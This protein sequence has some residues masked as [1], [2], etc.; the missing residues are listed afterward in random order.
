[1]NGQIAS[2]QE[3]TKGLLTAQNPENH[4]FKAVTGSYGSIYYEPVYGYGNWFRCLKE[5]ENSKDAV[6]Q[7][8]VEDLIAVPKMKEE[9]RARAL[10]QLSKQGERVC[11]QDF[12]EIEQDPQSLSELNYLANLQ[13]ERLATFV[14]V[15]NINTTIDSKA[16]I[17]TC[18]SDLVFVEYINQIAAKCLK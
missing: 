8:F 1:M 5:Y 18:L 17:A 7:S 4:L 15:K 2:A 11:E 13:Y 6:L 12:Q 16:P 10:L 3:S 14:S 9:I